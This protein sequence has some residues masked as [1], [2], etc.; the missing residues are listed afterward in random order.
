[1]TLVVIGPVTMDLIRIGD[2]ETSKVGGA[3]YFQSFVF[4]KFH[5]DY[6]VLVNC[7]DESLVNDFPDRGKVRVIEK[8][9]THFFINHYPDANDLNV[10]NQLSNFA[11]IPIYP[12]DL[13]DL[14]PDEIDGFVL[15]PLNRNDFPPETVEFLKTFNVPIFI[16]IQGFLRIPNDKVND[17]YTIRLE[18]FDELSD[19]LSGASVIF[20]DEA[21]ANLIGTGHDVDEMV[22]TNGS[23]GSR[24][25]AGDEIK[26][27]PV[28][29]DN[30]VDTTGCGD[31]FMASYVS[32]RLL[33]KTPE[34][35][36]NFASRIASEKISSF[37]PYKS[38]K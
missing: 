14:L 34:T 1:M 36:G 23:F 6:F 30:P 38:N 11:R 26:I 10:R 2:E 5:N 29:C 16:S 7:S 31:T 25:L 35:A 4:E 24:I 9:D 37:G 8:D 17:S 3:T 33:L 20:M 19:I 28:P 22:I 15:N 12:D 21:E 13:E 27:D 18:D 32:Q